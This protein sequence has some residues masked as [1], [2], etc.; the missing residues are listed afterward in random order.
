MSCSQSSHTV[1]STCAYCGVGCGIDITV[2]NGK[3]SALVGTI[4]HPANFGQLCVKGT[5][6]LATTDLTN[7]LLEPQI[8]NKTVDWS[9]ATNHVADK[10]TQII[11]E[12]GA[13]AVAFY[14]SGQLLTE[15]YYLANKLMKGYIGSAN[16]DTNSRLCMSSAVA[17]YKR[18]FGE[19]VVPCTYDDLDSTELLLITGSNA[20]WTHP[21]L[22]QRIERAKKRNPAM[23][24]VVID[25]RKTATCQIADY[26]LPIK[27]GTDAAFFNGLLNYLSTNN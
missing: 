18:S 11:K 20:A 3:A 12:H 26:F 13:D 16:I 22:F 24:I 19:D 27:P 1:Q 25:P 4:E 5:N 2:N 8:N 10:F 17:A 14:V 15:D 6:L 9:T 21:V 23:K 7:R